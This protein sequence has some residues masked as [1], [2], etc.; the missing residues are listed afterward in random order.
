MQKPRAQHL[1]IA[2]G[3]II[4][5]SPPADQHLIEVARVYL[6]SWYYPGIKDNH[7]QTLCE[8]P[9]QGNNYQE[10]GEGYSVETVRFGQSFPEI[11][12]HLKMVQECTRGSVSRHSICV[13]RKR[14][15]VV[16][17]F[18]VFVCLSGCP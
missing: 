7:L 13:S 18:D 17:V 3:L 1:D 4:V 15:L 8:I 11:M 10:D 5:A 16:Y 12:L 2:L 14:F 9:V 6:S